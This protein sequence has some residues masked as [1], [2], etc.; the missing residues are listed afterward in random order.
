M[1]RVFEPGRSARA[2][3]RH[4]ISL[5]LAGALGVLLL[6][7]AA[8]RA[9]ETAQAEIPPPSPAATHEGGLWERDV[10]AGDFGGQRTALE[11][12]GVQFGLNYIGEILGNPTGGVKQGLV[13][14]GRLEASFTL[15]LDKVAGWTGGLFHVNAYQIHGRGLSANDLG[16][17]LLTVSGIEA[18]R[19][20]RLFDLWLQQDL[21]DG[22]LQVRAG[23][24]AADDEFFISQYGAGFVNATFGWPSILAANLPSG[25]PVDPLATP[26]LRIRMTPTE[27]L[28]LSAAVLNGDPAGPGA[29][30]PQ[31]RDPSGTSFRLN[32]GA[33]AIAEGAYAINQGKGASGLPGIY[34]FGGWYHTG[35]FLDQ[36]FDGNGLSLANPASSGAAAV[37]QGNYGIYAIADQMVW[38]EADTADQGL[39]VFLR[40]S[41]NP[42]DRNLIDFYTDG[43]VS[44]KGLL[45]E[46]DDDALKFGVAYARV[47]NAAADLDRDADRLASPRPVRDFEIALE[48]SYLAQVTPWWAVQPDIQYIAHP[49][50]NIANPNSPVLIRAIPDALVVGLRTAITF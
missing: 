19:S 17:N 41:G 1:K 6:P 35:R 8:G 14:E 7:I 30:D 20:T 36:R 40:L 33:F 44:Y 12:R 3:H 25:G 32:D 9:E 45:P 39:G 28:T 18:T 24:I 16:N 2:L 13:Y 43:G 47:S 46:R 37:H 29:G 5:G 48:L 27:G 22:F 42:G 34:K 21:F 4:V 38:R 11:A 50:G 15:D 31:Q 49:G 10:L 26:G 23:Q